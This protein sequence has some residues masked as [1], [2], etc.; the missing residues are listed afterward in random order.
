[1]SLRER[2][3]WP[4]E[5]THEPVASVRSTDR[6]ARLIRAASAVHLA[7]GHTGNPHLGAFRTP[8]RSI[9]IIDR[10]RRAFESRT[11]RNN[12]RW[13]GRCVS[14]WEEV[15]PDNGDDELG[16]EAH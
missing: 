13:R 3:P 12:W 11:G 1:M 8:H 7:G 14:G 9:A 5:Q 2:A 16:E 15:P 6:R 10:Y 4:T